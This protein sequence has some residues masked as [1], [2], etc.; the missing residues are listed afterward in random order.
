MSSGLTYIYGYNSPSDERLLE[1]LFMNIEEQPSQTLAKA[2]VIL[3]AFSVEN[4]EWGI[5]ELSRELNINPTSTYNFVRT[6]YNAGYL[7]QNPENQRYSLG[8]KVMK[9]AGVYTHYTPMLTIVT[10]VFEDYSDRFKY[11]FYLGT[12]IRYEL[13]YLAVLDGRGPIKIVVDPGGTTALHSTALGK[14]LLAFQDEEYIHGF[15]DSGSLEAY[16]PRSITDPKILRDQLLEIREQGYAI[17]DGEHFE[18]VGAVGVPI[19]DH[20]GQ[21]TTGVSLAYPRYE[22]IHQRINVH[23]LI[24]LALEIAREIAERS[25]SD[26]MGS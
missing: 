12:L 19:Y 3:E 17:N 14:V 2:I 26:Y 18:D 21:V 9:L 16:T 1:A 15:L 25:G 11:N 7:T 8:P 13:V 4:S 23:E 6:L 22:L 24:D 5:R 20:S 10:K